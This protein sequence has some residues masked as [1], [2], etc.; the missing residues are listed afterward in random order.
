M[1]ILFLG[2]GPA[3]PTKERTN[4]SILVGSL[5]I[6]CA[7]MFLKQVKRE[8]IKPEDIEAVLITHAHK[9]A[10][11]GLGDLD[12]WIEKEIPVYSAPRVSIYRFIK[13]FKNLKIKKI[14]PHKKYKISRFSVTPFRVIHAE[15]FPTGKDFPCYGFRINDLVYA[16]DMERIP[17]SS[18]KYF[19]NADTIIADGAMWFG[20]QIRGHMSIDQT[21]NIGKKY[22]PNNLIIIQAG[23]TYPSQSKAEKEIKKH[24]D[25]KSNVILAY[26]GLKFSKKR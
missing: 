21:L 24:I 9:D 22:K 8:S 4:S 3:K 23:R 10:I 13:K 25:F 16:E 20:T 14:M 17:K 11:G 6:D 26:D 12:K 15:A 5:L 19:K 1:E 7:P 18:E 2:T